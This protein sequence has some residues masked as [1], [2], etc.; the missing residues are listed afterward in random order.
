MRM[1]TLELHA[2]LG[3]SRKL[4]PKRLDDDGERWKLRLPSRLRSKT[5]LNLLARYTQ[6]DSGFTAR[7]R[8]HALG[9]AKPSQ[10]VRP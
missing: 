6:G 1:P 3:S 5:T 10:R 8:R 9:A 7:L 2:W 4:K